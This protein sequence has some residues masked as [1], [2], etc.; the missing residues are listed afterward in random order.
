M[1]HGIVLALRK[2]AP[3]LLGI[4]IAGVDAATAA[5]AQVIQTQ[6]TPA[7]TTQIQA[8]PA[9]TSSAAGTRVITLG[10]AGGPLP[11]KDRAQPSN[12]LSVGGTLYLIDAGDGVTRRIVQT[13]YDFQQI[14]K[15]FITHCHS[16]HVA[17]LPGLLVARWEFQPRD[18]VDVYGS[19]VEELVR[20]A[21]AFLTPN[22]DIRSVQG[23]RTPMAQT[24]HGHDVVPGVVYQDGKVR[25]IAVENTHFH[26]PPGSRPDGKYRSYSYRFETPDRVIVFTGDTGPSEA[27]SDLAKNAD[28]L[29]TEVM[30][31]SDV[32]DLFKQRGLWQARTAEEQEGFVH[33][34]EGEHITPRAVGEMAARAGVK[35]IVMTH[36]GPTVDPEDNYQRYIDAARE[37]YAGPITIAKDL[38]EF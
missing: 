35:R 19:G 15:I 18:A 12:L 1:K 37:F 23:K 30:M 27:L 25:V 9:Q 28:V 38:M 3:L 32:I 10:T 14:D 31:A 8:A 36:L 26:F 16:D 13:G 34:M 7:Q 22:A 4:T 6:A 11:R 21:I 17:G 29:V 2:I 20:G 33:M 5:W 24:F